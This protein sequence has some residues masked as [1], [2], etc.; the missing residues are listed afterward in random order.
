MAPTG[1]FAAKIK[2]PEEGIFSLPFISTFTFHLSS[3]SFI[4]G[5]PVKCRL[6]WIVAFISSC[7][8]VLLINRTT[9]PG[10]DFKNL[11]F[12]FLIAASISIIFSIS[13]NRGVVNLFHFRYRNKIIMSMFFCEL[14][15]YD[16]V[17]IVLNR[18]SSRQ[19][20]L[21]HIFRKL[22]HPYQV[23]ICWTQ[24]IV[25]GISRDQKSPPS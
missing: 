6:L 11:L 1:W 8:M 9:K 4:N 7:W 18:L 23:L 2:R 17:K 22:W 25:S 20:R 5:T 10:R 21:P 3:T 16:K 12:P 13:S 24:R 14:R 15:I 19:D